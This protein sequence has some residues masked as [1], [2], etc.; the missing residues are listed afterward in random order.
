MINAIHSQQRVSNEY[1]R[2]M[3]RSNDQP[4]NIKLAANKTNQALECYYCNEA[5]YIINCVKFKANKDKYKLT[6]QQVKNNT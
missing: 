1:A 4:R 6:T 3:F 2:C 5:H